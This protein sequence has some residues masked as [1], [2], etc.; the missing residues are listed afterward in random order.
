MIQFRSIKRE[1]LYYV[2][3]GGFFS[4][5]LFVYLLALSYNQSQVR[6][7][8]KLQQVI[9]KKVILTRDV[10][11]YKTNLYQLT[12]FIGANL[13]PRETILQ[14]M[15][16]IKKVYPQIIL[17]PSS[18]NTKENTIELSLEII[19]TSKSYYDILDLLKT[20]SKESLPV[21]IFQ[22]ISI[23]PKITKNNGQIECIITG[24]FVGLK[25]NV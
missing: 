12:K 22:H 25:K 14:R 1:L 10:S 7:K 18:F 23:K 13:S 4:L 3:A 16:E 9:H 2:I 11:L 20:L 8:E 5:M 17:R 21:F 6:L 24:K 19:Y 15:D